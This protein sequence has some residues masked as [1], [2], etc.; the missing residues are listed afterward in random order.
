MRSLRGDRTVFAGLLALLVLAPLPFALA[1]DWGEALLSLVSFLMLLLWLMLALADRVSC[2]P[3]HIRYVALPL[4]LLLAVQGWA[5]I[6]TL[7]FPVQ[8]VAAIDED[9][10]RLRPGVLTASLS[11]DPYHSLRYAVL[12][13]SLSALFFLAFATVRTPRRVR[14]LLR[15]LLFS[16]TLQAGYGVFM[17][18][19][20]IEYGFLIEKYVGKGVVTGTFVNRNHLAGYLN[21]CLGAGIGLMLAQLSSDRPATWRDRLRAWLALLLSHK[22]RL[23][24]Y[25]AIMVV[26]LVM[27]R[28]RTGNIAFLTAIVIVGTLALA[29]RRRLD[30]K[31]AMFFVSLL[32]V[33]LMVIGQWFGLE[34][35]VERLEQSNPQ[36]E[37]R[38]ADYS[39]LL[40]VYLQ[41]FPWTGSGAGSF[42]SVFGQFHGGAL[43]M[44][45]AHAHND[46][47]QFAVEFGLP[48]FGLLGAWV[49]LTTYQAGQ[50]LKSRDA[51]FA[52]L[53]FAGLFMLVWLLIHS[54]TDFNLQIAANA[55][56]VMVLAGAIWGARGSSARQGGRTASTSS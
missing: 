12:G 36:V 48:A 2:R 42:Y 22:V 17:V 52:G 6:Q 53:G 45:P 21:I 19:S 54:G 20:G 8:W 35:L 14:W 46:Y 49:A 47:A 55:A 41:T 15:V 56:T 29:A 7:H 10:L 26:A 30:A 18:L 40:M 5:L 43:A 16:G 31:R 9:L 38:W 3:R 44:S 28:S 37:A 24:L 51:Y 25:L 23:R 1:R 4:G 33:D 11:L 50:L 39:P 13:C 34:A 32:F 27:S